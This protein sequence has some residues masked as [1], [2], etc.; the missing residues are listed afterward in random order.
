MLARYNDTVAA[1]RAALPEA[2]ASQAD[3]A[4][5]FAPE[6]DIALEFSPE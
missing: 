2:P 1:I 3:D 5:E 6:G 4:I